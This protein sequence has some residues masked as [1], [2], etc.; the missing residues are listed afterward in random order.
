MMLKE[1]LSWRYATK[2]MDSERKVSSEDIDY[3]KQC[4]QLSPSSYGLQ[5]YQVLEIA[6]PTLRKDLLP[7]SWNQSQ[8]VDASHLMVFCNKV[9]FTESDVDEY[10][11]LKSKIQETPLTQIIGYGDFVKKK[12][13]EK[14][15]E[16]MFHWTAKQAYIALAN[17]LNAC[18]ELQIDS[19][20]MEG[21]E[22]DQYN[23]QLNLNSRG[24]NACA[25]LA[26]GYRHKDDEAQNAN[27]VRKPI[28]KLFETI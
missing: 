13:N 17:A 6:N 20:P 10:L 18:A 8:I 11:K 5:P 1:K 3:I 15:S 7:L 21:F 4:I 2:K 25:V 16:E 23:E 27:K 14:T 12:L 9:Q 28:T 26:I 19:T 22:S 24:L